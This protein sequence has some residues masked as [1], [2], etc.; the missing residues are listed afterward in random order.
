MQEQ[1]AFLW[2]QLKSK[3]SKLSTYV[4]GAKVINQHTD[5]SSWSVTKT[6][7]RPSRSIFLRHESIPIE[8]FR[9]WIIIGIPRIVMIRFKNFSK[10]FSDKILHLNCMD[11]YLNYCAWFNWNALRLTFIFRQTIFFCTSSIWSPVAGG[12]YRIDSCNTAWR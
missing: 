7:I 9:I 12:C 6:S 1:I 2:N 8:L 11:R 5:T 10:N 3:F 4:F